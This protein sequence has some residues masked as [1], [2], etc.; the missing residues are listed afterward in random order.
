[1]KRLVDQNGK[2]IKPYKPR[3]PYSSRNS[4]SNRRR[5]EE[6]QRVKQEMI[7]NG[8]WDEKAYQNAKTVGFIFMLIIAA[9]ILYIKISDINK[10]YF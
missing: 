3:T 7:N 2:P 1:M 9:I 6:V 5:D 8:T 4:Y 10:G